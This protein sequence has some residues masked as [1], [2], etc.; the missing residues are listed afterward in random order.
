MRNSLPNSSLGTEKRPAFYD[1]FA[2]P[3]S[4]LFA[5]KVKTI[6][7]K[8]TLGRLYKY[9][10]TIS[11][12]VILVVA[13]LTLILLKTCNVIYPIYN[14]VDQKVDKPFVVHINELIDPIQLSNIKISP[15]VSGHWRFKGGMLI[16][17]DEIIFTP[18]DYFKAN[19]S[20][21]VDIGDVRRIPFGNAQINNLE[22]KTESAPS[23]ESSGINILS[24]N[25]VIAADYSFTINLTSPNDNL[26]NLELH[27]NPTIPL[28][29]T[30]VNDR[31]FTWKS[32]GLL[33][34]GSNVIVQLYDS[35]NDVVLM[36][37]TLKVSPEPDI[38]MP[39]KKDHF[40]VNDVAAIQFNQPIDPSS[41]RYIYFSIGG[42]GQWQ[43]DS[44]YTFTPDKVAPGQTYSYTLKAG[45]KSKSGGILTADR[46][47]TFSTVGPVM[48]IGSS[49]RG[50]GLSE[51]NEN[52]TFTFDQAVDHV[53]AQEHLSISS[54]RIINTSWQGNEIIVNIADLG[55]QQTVNA[56]LSAGVKNAGFGLPSVQ[57]FSDEFTTE[58]RTIKLNI[59]Y[60]HQQYAATCAAASLRM[61]LAYKGIATDDMSIVEKMGYNPTAENRSTN[62]PTWDDPW[63]MFV[64]SVDGTIRT[65]TGAGPDAQPVAKAAEGFGVSASAVTDISTVWIAQQVYNNHP[66][67]DFGAYS[68]ADTALTSW[69]T[70]SGRVEVMNITS[71][72]RVVTGVAGEPDNPIGFWVS[73]PIDGMAYWT[74][75]QMTLSISLDAYHQAVIVY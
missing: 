61:I 72:A 25:S 36:N 47:M 65:G 41:D 45:L 21:T 71:H 32:T 49:P 73:D 67:I 37:K 3:V 2:K 54:G 10:I 75:S 19:T 17:D 51:A 68:D 46:T 11:L 22:F 55:Y 6:F 27:I 28:V 20:Y 58:P 34:Q 18:S 26:R 13:C 48:V 62:P 50:N 53:S 40:G 23:L 63:N 1:F 9:Q 16:S 8:I 74:A 42:H 44:L 69:K 57:T 60:Y 5:M 14:T 29:Q 70:P 30:V 4:N 59:P 12:I 43:T 64:G 35:K 24:D 56:L 39:V 7:S 15:A 52:I 66:V 33:P 38:A 31:Q